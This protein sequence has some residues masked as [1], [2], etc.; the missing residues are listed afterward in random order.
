MNPFGATISCIAICL[1]ITTS[2]A[3]TFCL[4]VLITFSFF[5][6]KFI[7]KLA[8]EGWQRKQR[9]SMGF[10]LYYTSTSCGA[11][12]FI[13]ASLCDLS[14]ES[15]QVDI[16]EKKTAS[17]NDYLKINPK[18]NVPAIVLSDD[19][20]L[21]EN[22]ATLTYIADQN[23][24]AKLA[25]ASD[26]VPA[27]YQYLNA[28]SFVASELHPSFG[29]LFNPSLDDDAKDAARKRAVRSTKRFSDF[30]LN[31]KQ[32]V[33]EGDKPCAADIYAYIVFSWKG[34]LDIDISEVPGV[35][36]YANRVKDFPGVADAHKK[37]NDAAKSS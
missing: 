15:E 19:T 4:I 1:T 8:V 13:T 21:N 31:G 5:F 18:G 25:P 2:E 17:G 26:D 27:R 22:V 11:A 32:F 30:I 24:S 3:P 14:F 35:E 6:L 23:P 12:N 20:L 33:I 10:K 16:R 29:A 36:E 34:F 7:R 37:M 9:E 28:L